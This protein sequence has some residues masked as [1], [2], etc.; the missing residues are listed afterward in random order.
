MDVS[1]VTHAL[2]QQVCTCS[3]TSRALRC[4]PTE[5][6][7]EGYAEMNIKRASQGREAIRSDSHHLFYEAARHRIRNRFGGMDRIPFCIIEGWKQV[8]Y[9]EDDCKLNDLDPWSICLMIGN[10]RCHIRSRRR[11]KGGWVGGN[12]YLLDRLS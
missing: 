10:S 9:G 12:L 5:I 11:C 1:T 2:A 6:E 3:G 8:K 7:A 4:T